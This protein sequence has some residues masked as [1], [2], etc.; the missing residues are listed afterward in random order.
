MHCALAFVES[1][2]QKLAK[3]IKQIKQFG[4]REIDFTYTKTLGEVEEIGDFSL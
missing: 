3:C 4:N 1:G 2:E